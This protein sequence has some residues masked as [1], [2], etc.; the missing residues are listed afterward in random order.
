MDISTKYQSNLPIFLKREEIIRSIIDNQVVIVAGETGSGKTTQLPLFCLDA[1]QGLSGKII[2]TQPRRI[3]A[4][5]LANF[6]QG[7]LQSHLNDSVGYKVRFKTNCTDNTRIIFATDGILLSEI[8]DDPMLSR[9]SVIIIDEAHERSVNIDFLLGYL[10]QLLPQRKDLKLIISSAT[11][12]LK[13]FS[14]SFNNAPVI[15]VSGRLYPISIVYKPVIELWKGESMDSYIE[16]AIAVIREIL[17]VDD[18]GDVLV[19]LPAVGDITELCRR[20]E[21]AVVDKARL[22]PLHSRLHVSQ[23][24]SIFKKTDRRKIVVATNIA[25]TSI[26]V[27]GIKFV[28]DSGLVRMSRYDALSRLT[29]MPIEK[30]SKA[31][32]DQRAG[33]CGRLQDGICYRLYSE[34][35]YNS[36]KMFT[37]PEIQR[38]NLA[39]VIL[40]MSYNGLGDAEKFPFLQRP[41]I[42]AIRSAA[43]Q[44]MELG[45][46]NRK[47]AITLSGKEMARLPLDPPL[48]KMLIYAKDIDAAREIMVIVSGLAIDNPFIEKKELERKHRK[49][50]QRYES[51]YL[52]LLD[53]WIFCRRAIYKNGYS[54]QALFEYCKEF[55]L[56]PVKMTEWFDT[57]Y[58]IRR[59]C[60][61]IKGFNRIRKCKATY[62]SIH[63]SL[64]AGFFSGIA[65][66]TGNGVYEGIHVDDIR[67]WPSSVLSGRSPDWVLFHEIIE[68]TRVFGR[69]AAVIRPDWV[70][71]LFRNR[72]NYSIQDVWYDSES[73]V[74]KA[75]E[76]V[77]F[78]GLLL[79]T[80]R[81]IDL[82]KKDPERAHEIFIHDALVK[83]IPGETFRFVKHNNEIKSQISCL[84]NKMRTNIYL[85]D[86]VLEE[87][88]SERL[89]QVKNR[90]DLTAA[91][92]DN[93]NDSFLFVNIDDLVATELLK[94]QNLY[95][96]YIEVCGR[97]CAVEYLF[98]PG[99]E[100]DGCLIIV[101]EQLHSIVPSYYWQ[102]MLPV[103]WK[104]RVMLLLQH[105]SAQIREVGLTI[106]QIADTFCRSVI[107]VKMSFIDALCQFLKETCN[108]FLVYTKE[109]AG[110]IPAYL[111]PRIQVV[112]DDTTIV[113]TFRADF[114]HTSESLPP[115]VMKKEL[116]SDLDVF[117]YAQEKFTLWNNDFLN[118]V[119]AGSNNQ[120]VCFACY[121]ALHYDNDSFSV[122]LFTDIKKA[123]RAHYYAL[124]KIIENRSE[125]LLLWEVESLRIENELKEKINSIVSNLD[126]D[127]FVKKL[128]IDQFL[129]LP[130]VYPGD[131][132]AFN[133]II[134]EKKRTLGEIVL[135][136]INKLIFFTDSVNRTLMVLHKKQTRHAKTYLHDFHNVLRKD[137]ELY[138]NE[139][140]EESEYTHYR[141]N[142]PGIAGTFPSRIE[143]A[144]NNPQQY[145]KIMKEHAFYRNYLLKIT[146]Q[147]VVLTHNEI[148]MVDKC[149]VTLEN[150]LICQF[151]QAA[152]VTQRKKSEI[153]SRHDIQELFDTIYN[154]ITGSWC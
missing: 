103:F 100:C 19:F 18:T 89:P 61:T 31:S 134:D 118:A 60:R 63:K 14:R 22:I 11:I 4:I 51:D 101:H 33:R 153:I 124:Q 76:E 45:A 92:K 140:I 73:G 82:E 20:L 95:P 104:D 65:H 1:L 47:G 50:H 113:K 6:C 122:D 110:Y 15:L 136:T 105:F 151:E 99:D 135:N 29:R 28:I 108:L 90:R 131:Q 27:P 32:A 42:Q 68:T 84:Y 130:S 8:L 46:I 62:E 5:S 102:W 117:K 43:R 137:L 94:D 37:T 71:S 59:I 150:Y 24:Q 52:R 120:P 12:D 38:A 7:Q 35:D 123:D 139:L 74:V 16:G 53:T 146:A 66:T 25:E 144:Y 69:T 57:W 40:K 96:D 143:F 148:L 87:F 67:I 129:E 77:S 80:N 83:G 2:C 72:C 10:R 121:P 141:M 81:H 49:I 13:L 55:G 56:S 152:N 58:Q 79:L 145:L 147:N 26:T 23:Q 36:R 54:S 112:R 78:K 119:P 154:E 116:Y 128:V 44:L 107:M 125:E 97:R 41:S 106:E 133:S 30:V 98:S 48:A 21:P 64:L 138:T 85:G 3:A 109:Q 126:I 34:A 149:R 93:G 127:E 111:W 132:E 17:A 91:I 70:E 39:A 86:W 142:I 75:R 115:L 9:Y 88:Y 114:A